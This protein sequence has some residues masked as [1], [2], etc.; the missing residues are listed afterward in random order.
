MRLF[1][2]FAVLLLNL[3]PAWTSADVVK[4]SAS[5]PET[6]ITGIQFIRDESA[7]LT[8]DSIA[9]STQW[10]A[11]IQREPEFGFSKDAIWLQF[12]IQN[13]DNTTLQRLLE[14]AYPLLDDVQVWIY[15]DQR[16]TQ[17]YSI[18][19]RKPF[20][21]R[22]YKSPHFLIPLTIEPQEK[23]HFYLRVKSTSALQVPMTL[24]DRETFEQRAQRDNILVGS[25]FGLV[26]GIMLY[27]LFL[28]ATLREKRI[29]YYVLWVGSAT[30]FTAAYTGVAYEYLWPNAIYWNEKSVVFAISMALLSSALFTIEFLSLNAADTP[31]AYRLLSFF[32]LLGILFLPLDFFGPYG[33]AIRLNI[34]C[35]ILAVL[36]GIV[37]ATLRLKKGFK[38]A[39]IY[40]LSWSF[41]VIGL[42]TLALNKFGLIERT[43][44]TEF[45]PQIG[46]ALEVLLLSFALA[47][48]INTERKLREA[49]QQKAIQQERAAREEQQRHL[50]EEMQ[51]HQ[52]IVIAETE[53]KAK[54]QFMATMSHEIRTP[55]NG[56][57]GMAQLL[58]TTQL[59]P[60]QRQY[61]EVIAQSGQTLLTVIN[62]ILD[63]SKIESGKM[64][65]ESIDVDV[66]QLVTECASMFALTAESKGLKLIIDYASNTPR[67]VVSDPTRLRQILLNLIGNAFKFTDKG[68][69]FIRVSEHHF[70]EQKS[71]R[72]EVRDTGIGINPAQRERLFKAFSQADQSTTRKYGGTGLGL[73]IA[74][75]LSELLGGDMGVASE[76]GQGS[77]FWF[78]VTY[79]TPQPSFIKSNEEKFAA[80]QDKSILFIC[81][82]NDVTDMVHKNAAENMNIT[83]MHTGEA[84]LAALRDEHSP[85]YHMIIVADTLPDYLGVEI[86]RRLK[87]GNLHA[88]AI[89]VLLVP[90]TTSLEINQLEAIGVDCAQHYPFSMR[91]FLNMLIIAI[92]QYQS[93]HTSAPT[94]EANALFSGFQVLVAEDNAVNQMVIAGMLKRMGLAYKFANDGQT[95]IDQY[96]QDPAH[97]DCI[98]MDCEMP[99]MDGFTAASRLREFAQ[100]HALP[101]VPIIALTAH[102]L[103][104]HRERCFSAG[105]DDHLT[106]PIQLEIL[107]ATLMR[108]LKRND[109]NEKRHAAH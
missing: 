32:A 48:Q 87:Q 13:T 58:R 28:F 30:L 70:G 19:D 40:L 79:E 66:E 24:W 97:Y 75:R 82:A 42:S 52:K 93:K 15:S 61:L 43:L 33:I 35:S 78:T 59:E 84:A 45:A 101:R 25:Y 2:L 81:P 12:E 106:K 14:I 95:A 65:I 22:P 72:F 56:L 20:A 41:V 23:L 102:A 10:Q 3:L 26:L 77:T 89:K 6:R 80:L 54:S 37:I 68:G 92:Q 8:L 44:L 100:Q 64:D 60:Q 57:L 90:Y 76:A 49:A 88:D 7:S 99:V 16:Q 91:S 105:M 67:Y 104:E 36:I 96:A 18:G 34:F 85:Q 4:V 47:D 5:Q 11:V 38:V 62:D 73:V 69:V 71:L 31:F 27:N 98:L 94:Q 74:K 17:Q 107:K 39:R 83:L 21:E 46:T 55:M 29:L 63:F 108:Y 53:S 50:Q 103:A 9:S 86:I 1:F 109:D 51:A